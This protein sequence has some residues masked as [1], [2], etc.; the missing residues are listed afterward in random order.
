ELADGGDDR[1]GPE[2]LRGAAGS[3]PQFPGSAS[4]VEASGLHL[5]TEADVRIEVVLTGEG[6]EIGQDVG[7]PGEV[8][9]PVGVGGERV[10][11]EV[12]GDVNPTSRVDVLQPGAADGAV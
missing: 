10:G 8:L 1:L 7:L 12:V 11:V 2:G 4:L 5:G 6:I 3:D 9:R